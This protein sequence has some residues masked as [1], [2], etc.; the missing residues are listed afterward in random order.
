MRLKTGGIGLLGLIVAAVSIYG[1]ALLAWDQ[2]HVA[3][4]LPTAA[5]APLLS[6]PATTAVPAAERRSTPTP[7]T[8][9]PVK[10]ATPFALPTPEPGGQLIL[11]TPAPG[12][13]GWWTSAEARGNHLGDSFLYAGFY[14]G[15]AF[16]SAIRFDLHQIPRGAPIRQAI[17]RLTGLQEDRLAPEAGGTWTVQLLAI[18]VL[19][20]FNQSGFQE[21]FNAPAAV[22]FIPPLQPA[23]LGAGQVN[24]WPLDPSALEWLEQQVI[25]GAPSVIV[26]I[27][28]PV[29]GSDT[30]FA[31]DSGVGPATIGERPQLLLALGVPPPTP[32]SLVQTVVLPTSVPENVLTAAAQLLTA[33]AQAEQFGTPTPLPYYVVVATATLT[34]FVVTSTPTPANAA[35]AAALAAYATAVALTTG[36]FT[37]TPSNLVTAT[38]TPYPTPLPLL[39]YL[40][41]PTPTPVAT[42]TPS[43]VPQ[44]LV[45]K[46]LFFSDRD[47][48]TQLYALDPS[49]GQL[50]YVTQEWP[51]HVA[52]MAETRSPD[53]RFALVVQNRLE[54]RTQTPQVFLYDEQYNALIGLTATT[55]GSYDPVWSPRGDRIAF[56]SQEPD[57]DE[58]Y[59][60]N[61][62]G[63]DL[64]R[65][66]VNHWE[67][68]KHP[69]WSPDG[70]Q[71]VFWSNRE[72]GRRQLWVMNSD[73]SQQRRL[74]ES[75]YND[76]DPVWVK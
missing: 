8:T 36:T 11:L 47:S 69:S 10:A 28:G 2:G 51:Y 53:G 66:T 65:L 9:F 21:L 61:P 23:D 38:F 17:L 4:A 57:N 46:I 6:L 72:T 33:T 64:Q 67:W 56:V 44:E 75:P 73:G 49:T 37:P 31:W 24:S 70:A 39:I 7:I 22:T 68:D 13:A 27:L 29:S 16:L 41:Q 26:R 14:E 43:T 54:D 62:D 1:C 45:G 71:I 59:T 48:R 63:S 15:R 30:L 12:S 20:S 19:P 5:A 18:E 50:A 3:T 58:I 32:L 55:G 40:D 25:R 60:I 42:P 74:L 76:W 34:P 52:R 35:T